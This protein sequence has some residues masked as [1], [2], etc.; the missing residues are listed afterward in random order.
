MREMWTSHESWVYQCCRCSATWQEDY[1]VRHVDDGHGREASIYRQAGQQITPPWYD[2]E[3]PR[4]HSAN[5]RAFTGFWNEPIQVR[6][7]GR[8][9]D[10]ALIARLRRIG[11]Y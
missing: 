5:V 11:A 9:K 8:A 10:L 6:N 7:R 3:C 4:C 2:H 1:D